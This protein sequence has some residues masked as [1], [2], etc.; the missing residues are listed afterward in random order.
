MAVGEAIQQLFQCC[1]GDLGDNSLRSNPDA[2]RGT[3]DELLAAIKSLSVI[4]VAKSVRRSNLLAVKQDHSE[5]VRSFYARINGK[6]ATCTYTMNCPS[7]T[8]QQRVD[9]TDMIVKDVLISGLSDDDIRKD[10]LGWSELDTKN[11]KDGCCVVHRIKRNGTRRNDETDH[12]CEC[13]S[14]DD[15]DKMQNLQNRN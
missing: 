9:F 12:K 6:A 10:V 15:K 1:E 4:P 5:N 13:I 2:T 11:V 3:E 8:C 14:E 7:N